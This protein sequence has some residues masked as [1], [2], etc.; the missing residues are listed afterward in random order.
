VL[1]VGQGTRGAELTYNFLKSNRADVF[2]R[3]SRL[4]SEPTCRKLLGSDEKVLTG[5]ILQ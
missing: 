2:W 4:G 3:L 5:E 1:G